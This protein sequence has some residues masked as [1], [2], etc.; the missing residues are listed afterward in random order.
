LGKQSMRLARLSQN[1]VSGCCVLPRG[2]RHNHDRGGGGDEKRSEVR[3]RGRN[4]FLRT[5]ADKIIEERSESTN[6]D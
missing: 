6:P 5:R 1:L 2:G 3:P 4:E